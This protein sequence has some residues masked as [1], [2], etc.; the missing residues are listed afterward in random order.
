MGPIHWISPDI[1]TSVRRLPRHS[2]GHPK[3]KREYRNMS[4]IVRISLAACVATLPAVS[5]AAQPAA[6]TK[7]P[8]TV[9]C[10][11]GQQTV[12]YSPGMTNE[13]RS[14]TASIKETYSCGTPGSVTSATS[15]FTARE[16]ANCGIAFTA[17]DDKA[18][19]TWN[20]P[21]GSSTIAYRGTRVTRALDGTTTIV[22]VGSVTH[23]LGTGEVATR[24]V[25]LPQTDLD[26]CNS[27]QGLTRQ[28]GTATLAI[29]PA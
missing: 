12:N 22:S 10:L 4:R 14:V 23:G 27:S 25:V 29:L 13:D 19:Y 18:T 8:E 3:V 26:A 16:R 6:A 15:S 1:T 17:H 28:V 11:S 7:A 9:S 5:V 24:T 21:V 2:S 20:S